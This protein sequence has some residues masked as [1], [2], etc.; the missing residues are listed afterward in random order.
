MVI[1]RYIRKYIFV[2]FLPYFA[3]L[4]VD[5]LPTI[6][7][8]KTYIHA[9]STYTRK[10]AGVCCNNIN[11]MHADIKCRKYYIILLIKIIFTIGIITFKFT[12]IKVSQS[13]LKKE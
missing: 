4:F 2:Y 3:S 9:Y 10:T 5:H 7:R 11:R 8:H 12:S 13:Y 6:S 1:F